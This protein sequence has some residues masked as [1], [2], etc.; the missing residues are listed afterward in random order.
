[1]GLAYTAQSYYTG[2]ASFFRDLSNPAQ[3]FVKHEIGKALQLNAQ[4]L[5]APIPVIFSAE[6]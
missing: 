2:L 6:Y 5:N 1:M 4:V 3:C